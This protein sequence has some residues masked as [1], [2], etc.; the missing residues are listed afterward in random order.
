VDGEIRSPATTALL[1]LDP[2]FPEFA[3]GAI[4]LRLDDIANV[5]GVEVELSYDPAV[6][7]VPGG[8]LTPG[9][10]PQPDFLATN[11]AGS[12]TIAYAATHLYPTPPCAGG[13][14]ATIDLAC[15]P[16]LSVS[17]ATDIVITSSLVTNPDGI[18]IPHSVQNAT[19]TCLVPPVAAFSGSPVSGIAPL[20]VDFTNLSSGDFDTCSWDFGDG[21]T[22]TDCNDPSHGYTSAGVYTATLS[23]TGPGGSAT[24]TKVD[25]I[26]VYEPVSAEFSA[27]PTGGVLPLVVDFTNL[28]NG[29]FDNCSW[30]FG[31]GT[32]SN[33][34][35]GVSHTYVA[36]GV[37]TVTLTV[38]GQG[39]S[40]TASK[41]GYIIVAAYDIYLPVLRKTN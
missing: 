35:V 41:P 8:N 31:D 25:Y 34:C 40:D 2:P 28:S 33:A 26:T 5:Y 1:W 23:V 22:S 10:C 37:Y 17:T 36:A 21:H 13:V 39:G 6:I 7:S 15:D 3:T 19:V 38:T 18:P 29:D 16:N 12:G 4:D 20:A 14:I 9:A 11:T 30:D 27:M 24:E 32:T